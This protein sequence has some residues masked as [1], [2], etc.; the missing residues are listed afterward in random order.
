MSASISQFICSQSLSQSAN[1]VEM[2]YPF[3]YRD[4]STSN[5]RCLNGTVCYF[6]SSVVIPPVR[7]RFR[8]DLVYLFTIMIDDGISAGDDTEGERGSEGECGEEEHLKR[9]DTQ[10]SRPNER[11]N[12]G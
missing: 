7:R 9:S 3:V 6:D 1:L 11:A 10:A 8:C 2:D 12:W 4:C 5:A